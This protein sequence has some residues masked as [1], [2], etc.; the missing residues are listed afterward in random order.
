M[1]L[2][3]LLKSNL[4]L[5]ELGCA[6]QPRNSRNRANTFGYL[7]PPHEDVQEYAQSTPP[8]PNG[9]DAKVLVP[10]KPQARSISRLVDII[11]DAYIVLA[12]K[13]GV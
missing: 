6:K 7:Q 9:P 11:N 8:R 12:R 1:T 2:I 4:M 5:V 13:Q 10:E 3:T